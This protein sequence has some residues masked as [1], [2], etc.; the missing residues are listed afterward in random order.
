MVI[1]LSCGYF[2]IDFMAID[3]LLCQCSMKKK[4]P[5]IV[6]EKKINFKL[7]HVIA[8]V[9]SHEQMSAQR[10]FNKN[11]S[12]L[13]RGMCITQRK[14]V[15]NYCFKQCSNKYLFINCNTIMSRN[16]ILIIYELSNLDHVLRAV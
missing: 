14:I 1:I 5:R 9:M 16:N 11:M 8:I 10:E 12:G 2:S 3:V 13:V 6:K 4:N 15:Y 7:L